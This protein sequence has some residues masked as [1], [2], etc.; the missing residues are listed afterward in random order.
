MKSSLR[1][2]YKTGKYILQKEGLIPFIKQ[3]ISFVVRCFF[4][5][6]TYYLYRPTLYEASEV[7]PTPKIQNF[8]LEIISTREQVDELVANGFDLGFHMIGI[9]ERLNKGAIAF[10]VFVERDL[11]Y[12]AWVAMSE[13]AKNSLTELPYPVDFLNGEA[14]QG[15]SE[16][17]PRY[18]RMGIGRYV[19]FK[20]LQYLRDRGRTLHPYVVSKSNLTSQEFETKVGAKCCG[21][22]RY[23]KLLW[24][25]FWKEKPIGQ[26][27][28]Y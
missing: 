24:W 15:W 22:G 7:E 1:L 9:E 21:E 5:Y 12:I 23:L 20:K 18:R 27:K 28:E 4:S 16:T 17:S 3:G 6:E 25:K 14:Y 10:C 19:R 13:E 11:A 26:A 8:T 2:K